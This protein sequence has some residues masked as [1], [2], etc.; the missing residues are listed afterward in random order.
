MSKI[1]ITTGL[2]F[3]VLGLL[4]PLLQKLNFGS[5]PGDFL[6]KS[7]NFKVY[8][9]LT[10]CLVISIVISILFWFFRK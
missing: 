9:P 6:F 3:L 7:G 2:I 4:W 5:L 10:T 8:F 1:L